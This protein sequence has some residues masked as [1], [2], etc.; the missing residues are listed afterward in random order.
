MTWI[1]R[2]IGWFWARVA[3]STA[4]ALGGLG[5]LRILSALFLLLV[6]PP[7]AYWVGAAPPT[8]FAPPRLSPMALA[9]GFP[10]TTL[11]WLAD[12]TAFVL[13]CC[14]LL[15][16]RA[17]LATLLLVVVGT[18]SSNAAMSFG[19]IDH[20]A[21]LWTF[22]LCMA[23]SGWGHSLALVPDKPS[24]LDRPD[25]AFALMAVCLGF[26]MS[27]IGLYKVRGWLDLDLE[28]SGFLKWFVHGYFML[29]RTEL[30][31]KHVPSIPPLGLELMDYAGVAFESG[32]FVALL[33][34]RRVWRF[35]ITAAC[36]F[37]LTNVLTLN[38]S[39]LQN[40]PIYWAF[41]DFSAVQRSLQRWWARRGVRWAFG[42]IGV[43]MVLAHLAVRRAGVGGW[44]LFVFDEEHD[45]RLVLRL[46][47]ILFIVTCW[48]VLHDQIERW[49]TPNTGTPIAPRP[50]DP[51]TSA[52]PTAVAD[53][54]AG[55]VPLG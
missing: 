12:I 4:P 27:I 52:Q 32:C 53:R 38:I 37:H 22:L 23:F 55:R 26:S 21:M 50:A 20:D 9:S 2:G 13:I 15:G 54:D 46:S 49:R 36:V 29:D 1:D 28:T 6:L 35:W 40:I 7:Y 47:A 8:F 14:V 17:R 11:M 33:I 16:V 24:R 18:L 3:A 5:F 43:A 19:K 31:A 41:V 45:N 34:G 42:A 39:F 48:V 10:S 25:R 30:L 51:T 44:L